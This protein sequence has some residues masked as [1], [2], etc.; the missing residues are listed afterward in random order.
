MGEA[1]SRRDPIASLLASSDDDVTPEEAEHELRAAGVDVDAFLSRARERKAQH[2][3]AERTAWRRT[4]RAEIDRVAPVRSPKYVSMSRAELM[5]EYRR[6]E[7]QQMTAF[8]KLETVSDDDLR[9]LLA[10]MDDL[11]DEPAE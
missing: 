11:E 3:E 2:A 4:A 6:R 5:G 1:K 10:D 8:H 9:S 7:Q